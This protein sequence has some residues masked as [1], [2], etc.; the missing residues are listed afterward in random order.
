MSHSCPGAKSMLLQA[1]NLIVY[2][3]LAN[4]LILT[5][6]YSDIVNNVRFASL[7]KKIIKNRTSGPLCYG[8]LL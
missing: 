3:P 1:D 8:N 4:S 7:E 6:L 2:P 5:I